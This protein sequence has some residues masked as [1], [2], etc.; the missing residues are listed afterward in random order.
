MGDRSVPSAKTSQQRNPARLRTIGGG[1]NETSTNP[2]AEFLYTTNRAPYMS[3]AMFAAVPKIEPRRPERAVE[4]APRRS[5]V[6]AV[7]ATWLV[8]LF[9][10]AEIGPRLLGRRTWR[11]VENPRGE[12]ALHEPDPTLGWVTKPGFYRLPP[13]LPGGA[14]REVTIL[15]DHSRATGAPGPGDRVVL[16]GCSITHGYGL[17]DADTLAWKLQRLHPGLRIVNFGTAAYGTF[18]SLLRMEQLLDENPPPALVL[19]GFITQHEARNVATYDWLRGLALNA[20]RGHVAPPYVT[21][22]AGDTLERH[23]PEAFSVW[24]LADYL[25]TVRMADD[26]YMHVVSYGRDAQGVEA[27]KRLVSEM[28]D[29]ARG[30]STAFAVVFLV[31]QGDKKEEYLAYFREHRIPVLDCVQPLT[32]DNQ[33][34]GEGHPNAKLN[35]IWAECISEKLPDLLRR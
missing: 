28:A 7:A 32:E 14:V 27:T 16:V 23:P 25:V 34:P 20:K 6:L 15:P 3:P 13:H 12:P 35:S 22:G 21:L 30:R 5:V 29:V 8:A 1:K 18:Q 2:D 31:A 10:V 24:P 17:S 4:T 9:A 33:I 11:Y 19:Y 26:A